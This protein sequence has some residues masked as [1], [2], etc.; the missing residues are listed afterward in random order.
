[1]RLMSANSCRCAFT[2]MYVPITIKRRSGKVVKSWH[3]NGA[4]NIEEVLQFIWRDLFLSLL[5]T[6]T[7]QDIEK[8]PTMLS[9]IEDIMGWQALERLLY[10]GRKCENFF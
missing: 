4:H 10:G 2:S 5:A 3:V 9:D 7:Q 6:G 1:M 8:I